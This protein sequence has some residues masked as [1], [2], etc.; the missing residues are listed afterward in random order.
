[1]HFNIV[2]EGK[3]T[4]APRLGADGSKE[5]QWQPCNQSDNEEPAM[6]EF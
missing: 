4:D 6:Q 1:M 2:K 5:Q 3:P